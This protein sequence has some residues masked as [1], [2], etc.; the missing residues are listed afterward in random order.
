LRYPCDY[1][2]DIAVQIDMSGSYLD[3]PVEDMGRQAELM[4]L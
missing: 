3:E 1:N 2:Q 4:V